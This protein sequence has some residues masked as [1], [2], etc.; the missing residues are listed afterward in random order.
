MEKLK[1]KFLKELKPGTIIISNTF[2]ISGL[3]PTQIIEINDIYK[4]KVYK[5]IIN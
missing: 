5:Y 2:A 3:K 4:T 1:E